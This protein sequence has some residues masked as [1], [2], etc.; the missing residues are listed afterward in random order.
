MLGMAEEYALDR[1]ADTLCLNAVPD[2][3]RFY[4]RHGYVP[5]RWQGCTDNPTETP[6]VKRL[7]SPAMPLAGYPAAAA[8]V[9]MPASA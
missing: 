4:A 1:G 7:A 6:V 2:A 9:A 5:E 8:S 3:F